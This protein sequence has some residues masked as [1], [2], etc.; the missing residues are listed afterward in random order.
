MGDERLRFEY[1]VISE[2]Y[3]RNDVS[4]SILGNME[5]TLLEGEDLL[6][7]T[8]TGFPP[9]ETLRSE[10][11]RLRVSLDSISNLLE[12][13]FSLNDIT[14]VDGHASHLLSDMSKNWDLEKLDLGDLAWEIG[15]VGVDHHWVQI[16]AMRVD[17]NLGLIRLHFLLLA[18]S[19]RVVQGMRWF[20]LGHVHFCKLSG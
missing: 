6:L 3:D 17:D 9:P 19:A 4:I 14:S 8:C 15:E 1:P 12:T 2:E 18:H 20:N 11:D 13:T 16:T 7:I 10:A 5:G